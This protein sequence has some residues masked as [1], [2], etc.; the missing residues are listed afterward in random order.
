VTPYPRQTVREW[1]ATPGLRGRLAWI[2]GLVVLSFLTAWRLWV[3]AVVPITQDEAYHLFW[4]K[5]LAWGY[6][7]HP[8]LIAVLASTANLVRGSAFVA[9]LGV[10]MTGGVVC[11]LTASFMK[12]LG[13]HD[14]RI[15]LSAVLIAI[16]NLV[17]LVGGTLIAPDAALGL[18]WIVALHETLAALKGARWRWLSAGVGVGLAV[19]AK[20]TAVLLF[21]IALVAIVKTRP[22]ALRTPWPY[23]GAVVGA[24]IVLPNVVWN[25]NHQWVSLGFQLAHGF[26]QAPAESRAADLP[27]PIP[28][29]A[30]I[31]GERLAAS[32]A[33]RRVS[34]PI[35]RDTGSIE[36][37]LRRVS[38]FW[39]AQLGLWGSFA[40]F[41]IVSAWRSVRRSPGAI[42]AW[43]GNVDAQARPLVLAATLVPLLFFAVLSVVTKVEANW[44]AMY[45]LG[46]AVW[47][48]SL[49]GARWRLVLAASLLN[50]A[51]VSLVAVHAAHPTLTLPRDRV[52]AETHGFRELAGVVSG[53]DG[54]VSAESYQLVSML[55]FYSGR[56]SL[57]QWPGIMRDS[58]LTRPGQTLAPPPALADVLRVG[59]FWLVTDSGPLQAFPSFS[60][61]TLI[62]VRDCGVLGVQVTEAGASARVTPRC[63]TGVHVWYVTEYALAARSEAGGR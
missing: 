54:P 45:V 41:W 46:G 12:D 63:K 51:L 6:F 36:R 9:R 13:F 55:R 47:L 32:F 48:A 49:V 60:A 44:P 34:T 53:L 11:L 30:G 37:S 15:R 57:F 56:E 62:E 52:L 1:P 2:P 40:I 19:L 18:G 29:A 17:A 14:W 24:C 33:E 7:D 25:A 58:E 39:A 5:N 31:V 42:S 3:A 8:P 26:G 38:G 23:L 10:V 20:Y 4:A 21:P 16:C 22:S 27:R 61:A 43:S 28:A 35:A 59:H 50:V